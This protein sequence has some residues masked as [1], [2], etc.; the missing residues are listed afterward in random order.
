[1]EWLTFF[2]I[3]FSGLLKLILMIAIILILVG[4]GILIFIY[5]GKIIQKIRWPERAMK[6]IGKVILIIIGIAIG[7]YILY[8]LFVFIMILGILPWN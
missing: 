8:L 7:I 3:F 1:M 5:L 4:I 6:K 2:K